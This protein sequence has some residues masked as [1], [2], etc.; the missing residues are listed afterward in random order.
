MKEK[1]NVW[2]SVKNA[3]LHT[4]YIYVKKKKIPYLE[5]E[6]NKTLMVLGWIWMVNDFSLSLF[7]SSILPFLKISKYMFKMKV[8]EDNN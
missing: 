8:N 1:I 4:Q 3:K 6:P 2:I 7:L 5:K